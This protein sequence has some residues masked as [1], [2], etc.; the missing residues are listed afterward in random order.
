MTIKKSFTLIEMLIVI[1]IIGILAAALVPRLQ[2]VQARARDT[3]RKTDIRTIY[4]ADEIYKVDNWS[5][6]LWGSCAYNANCYVYSS[7]A[8]WSAML[9]WIITS[10]PVDPINSGAPTWWATGNYTYWYGNIYNSPVH[11]YDLMA[12]LENWQD[13][14]RCQLKNY[15]SY[16]VGSWCGPYNKYMYM[17]WPYA[18]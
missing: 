8:S 13:P 17:M 18:N 3:K 12:Q 2:S 6:T 16:H 9:T 15:Q 5:Y 10:M 7:A 14:D 11:A 1:V 4:N